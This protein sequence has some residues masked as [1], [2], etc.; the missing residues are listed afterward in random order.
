LPSVEKQKERIR[1]KITKKNLSK[2]IN[3]NGVKKTAALNQAFMGLFK[4]FLKAGSGSFICPHCR[5]TQ[6][7]IKKEGHNKF[8]MVKSK[9]DI[10]TSK[11]IFH[12]R[13][14]SD[15]EFDYTNLGQDE[16]LSEN[17]TNYNLK[18]K[19]SNG[20]P[21]AG[22]DSQNPQK[23]AKS[24]MMHPI[25]VREQVRQLWQFNTKLMN[26][27]FGNLVCNSHTMTNSKKGYSQIKFSPDNFFIE[28]LAVSPNRFRPE[29][30]LADQTY[31]HAH[32]VSYQKV[33]QINLQIKTMLAAADGNKNTAVGS[34]LGPKDS[35][36]TVKKLSLKDAF[37]K[38]LEL[39]DTVNSLYDSTKS[40]KTMA[41]T[42]G[43]GIKQLLEK[44]EGM[45]RMK[46]MGKRVNFAARSVISPDPLLDTNEVGVP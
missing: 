39:Q 22:E 31:L 23:K 12:N 7:Q 29:N 26:L 30:K 45:F 24:T 35:M 33:L 36:D 8:L 10:K 27:I 41:I 11:V 4:E 18:H 3:P 37:S 32:T 20:G 44:K 5:H 1:D 2:I 40:G 25:E 38:C 9:E 13:K 43:T 16:S 28:V 6:P 17:S 19:N 15:D 42:D 14:A 34:E 21:A 46:I